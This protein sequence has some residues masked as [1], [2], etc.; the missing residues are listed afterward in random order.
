MR[1][2][3]V[4]SLR[5]CDSSARCDAAYMCG[6]CSHGSAPTFCVCGRKMEFTFCVVRVRMFVSMFMSM[7]CDGGRR[8]HNHTHLRERAH[9]TFDFIMFVRLEGK[10]CWRSECVRIWN[11]FCIADDMLSR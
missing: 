2:V 10:T 11:V 6:N 8:S 4:C 9:K 5:L 1:F 7:F 3:C